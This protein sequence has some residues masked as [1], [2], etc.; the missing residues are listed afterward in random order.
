MFTGLRL[1][2]KLII[3]EHWRNDSHILSY[4]VRQNFVFERFVD[5]DGNGC[6]QTE[7]TSI[8]TFLSDLE[9]H[10]NTTVKSTLSI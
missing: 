4:D 8:F 9:E 6:K 7:F 5:D 1:Q 10:F 3:A 2:I